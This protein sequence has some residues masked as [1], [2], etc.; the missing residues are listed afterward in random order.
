[1]LNLDIAIS[2]HH[3]V[4][5][6]A[7]PIAHVIH[8]GVNPERF[9]VGSGAGDYLASLGRMAPAKGVDTAIRVARAAGRTHRL[10][11]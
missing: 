3:A 6:G 11:L 10:Y 9:A 8:H 2:E 5:A 7:I 1:V 4:S